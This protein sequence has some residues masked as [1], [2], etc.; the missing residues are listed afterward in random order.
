MLGNHLEALGRAVMAGDQLR[1]DQPN[2]VPRLERAFL[3]TGGELLMPNATRRQNWR[4][5]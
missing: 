5:G 3:M 2:Y 1:G 4:S